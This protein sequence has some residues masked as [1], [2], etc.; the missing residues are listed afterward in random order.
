MRCPYLK[1]NS[2][3]RDSIMREKLT[4]MDRD[5]CVEEDCDEFENC[6]NRG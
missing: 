5:E 2:E 4:T 6:W 3:L 1:Q